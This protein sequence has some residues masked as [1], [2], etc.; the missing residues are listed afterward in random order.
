[1]GHVTR[2]GR[3]QLAFS[4]DETWRQASGAYPLSLS[5]PLAGWKRRPARAL[6]PAEGPSGRSPRGSG[7]SES[8]GQFTG[9]GSRFTTT[10]WMSSSSRSMNA[11]SPPGPNASGSRAAP[12]RKLPR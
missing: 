8:R 12:A 6:R 7:T 3:G 5:M 11:A 9:R 10:V 1:M 2:H 4:Y